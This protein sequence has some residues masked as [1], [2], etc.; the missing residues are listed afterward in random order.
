MPTSEKEINNYLFDQLH[1]LQRLEKVAKRIGNEEMLEAIEE[2]KRYV[3]DKLYQT[4]AL[5]KNE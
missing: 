1:A 2:E 3:K 5:E 4:P